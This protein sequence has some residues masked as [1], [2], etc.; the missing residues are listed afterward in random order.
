MSIVRNRH[1]PIVIEQD[2]D[3]IY[4]VT[5]PVLRGCHSYGDTMDEAVANINEAI[6]ACLEDEIQDDSN[7]FIGVRDV[8]LAI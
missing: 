5:C 8:E 6:Q 1:Y 7:T 3:G 4:I 2:P